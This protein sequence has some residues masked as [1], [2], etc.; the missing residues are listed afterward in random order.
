M[1]ARRKPAERIKPQAA[2]DS[3]KGSEDVVCRLSLLALESRETHDLTT[4]TLLF[5]HRHERQHDIA[6]GVTIG[7][8]V[9]LTSTVVATAAALFECHRAGDILECQADVA[10]ART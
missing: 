5:V 2:D 10:E 9:I 7:I 4:P 1:G 6:G 8:F 3:E